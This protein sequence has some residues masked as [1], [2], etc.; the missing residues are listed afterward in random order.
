MGKP[1]RQY[2]DGTSESIWGVRRGGYHY[3]QALSHPLKDAQSEKEIESYNYPD[4]E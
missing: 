4:P 1:L 2:E 3:G